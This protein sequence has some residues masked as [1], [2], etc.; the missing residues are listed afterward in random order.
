M[1]SVPWARRPIASPLW[2]LAL[3]SEKW[4]WEGDETGWAFSWRLIRETETQARSPEKTTK[5]GEG[6]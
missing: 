5:A 3:S 2:G 4:R 6:T 1:A